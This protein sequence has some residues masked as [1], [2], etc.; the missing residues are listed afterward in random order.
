M[1]LSDILDTLG[2]LV[3]ALVLAT[4]DGPYHR[5]DIG[6][7]RG[8]AWSRQ[9]RALRIDPIEPGP[10]IRRKFGCRPKDRFD[11]PPGFQPF[12]RLARKGA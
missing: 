2:A 11:Q 10:F 7:D 5:N 3:V 4:M 8:I 9:S 1:T 12:L 6:G